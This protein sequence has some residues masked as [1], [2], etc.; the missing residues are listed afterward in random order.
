MHFQV[1]RWLRFSLVNLLLVAFM[2]VVLRYKIL[3]PL[4][5]VDQKHL[6][7]GHS[8]FAFAGWITQTLMVLMIQYLSTRLSD[9]IFKKYRLLLVANLVTAY[10]ML[11]S[12]PVQ[13]YG[14]WSISFSTASIFVSYT[15]ALQFLR[16]LKRISGSQPAHKWFRFA[17]LCS[18]LSSLGAFALAFMM[19]THTLH[20]SW[21]LLA[22]YFFLHFQY[23]GWFFFGCAGL[24]VSR[25]PIIPVL[26][27]TSNRIFRL[28]ALACIP[29]YFLSVLWL[30]LPV[31]VYAIVVLSSLAQLVGAGLGIR[32]FVR[33]KATILSTPSP[34]GRWLLGLSAIACL[35]KLLLQAGST[36]P[37]LSQLAFGF[38]PI[39]IGYLHLVLLGVISIFLIGYLVCFELVNITRNRMRGIRIFIAGILLNETVLMLQGFAA[40]NYH[41]LPYGNHLLLGIALVLLAGILLI[42]FS[43]KNAGTDLNHKK[44]ITGTTTL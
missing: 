37:S 24:L 2:G 12:F 19:A 4:P 8:H 30:P 5:F 6:L 28:F 22:V 35:I 1:N 7:H 29:A 21:Y 17:L 3:F 38:R 14:A 36:H 15:F 18:V 34:K 20:Q 26:Q 43:G 44:E 41:S 32:L 31:I 33:H 13:G 11:V 23:N 10:G 42:A 40:L 39:V 9:S 16:D 25:L 27:K